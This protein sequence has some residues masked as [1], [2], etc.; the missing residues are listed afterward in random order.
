MDSKA[1]AS[2]TLQRQVVEEHV[3]NGFVSP[4]CSS[5]ESATSKIQM[6]TL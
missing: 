6:Y 2:G 3:G 5:S 1:D 4:Y